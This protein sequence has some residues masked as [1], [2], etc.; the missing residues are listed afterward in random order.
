[1]VSPRVG[2]LPAIRDRA[3]TAER[4]LWILL[5]DSHER[6]EVDGAWGEAISAL[7][8]GESPCPW[9]LTEPRIAACVRAVAPLAR[10]RVSSPD[11]PCRRVEAW[12]PLP[13]SMLDL[14]FLRSS[15]PD[16]S[17]WDTV[18][19]FGLRSAILG[20][21]LAKD[22]GRTQIAFFADP[23][24][25]V[26]AQRGFGERAFLL[27]RRR[28][29]WTRTLEGWAIGAADRVETPDADSARRLE[30]IFLPAPGRILDRAS[31]P[32]SRGR[33]SEGDRSIR[34]AVFASTHSP[35]ANRIVLRSLAGMRMGRR[36][37]I[38][39]LARRGGD[40]AMRARQDFRRLGLTR[41]LRWCDEPWMRP[42]SP[43]EPDWDALIQPD[44]RP[45]A[46]P[47]VALYRAR[48]G[49]TIIP[50]GC[51]E[52]PGCR[53]SVVV[54]WVES[55]LVEVLEALVLGGRMQVAPGSGQRRQEEDS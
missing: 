33:R 28:A 11:E 22:T 2:T 4:E 29:A 52:I 24:E 39:W 41:N 20:A 55:S 21:V 34:L 16:F 8:A 18:R 9:V 3:M 51:D 43:G 38:H 48:A 49:I 32:R 5:A 31:P 45:G 36:L 1:M 6:A 10:V 12:A 25:D 46:W 17:C 37:E 23:I 7:S 27:G 47:L 44:P 53:G 30:E 35:R 13:A 40:C 50:R 14:L 54:P 15:V 26:S 19:S 42:P